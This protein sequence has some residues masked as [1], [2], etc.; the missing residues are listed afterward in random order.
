MYKQKEHILFVYTSS[1]IAVNIHVVN[2]VSLVNVVKTLV[3]YNVTFKVIE[4]TFFERH[5]PA[6]SDVMFF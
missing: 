3:K 2:V 6:R 5:E 1:A 4:Q